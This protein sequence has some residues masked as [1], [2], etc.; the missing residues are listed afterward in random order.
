MDYKK[1]NLTLGEF[2]FFING[3]ETVVI[4]SA[5]DKTLWHG[6]AKILYTRS[7]NTMLENLKTKY[8]DNV[9][10]NDY[11]EIVIQLQ[12]EVTKED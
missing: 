9:N 11:C 2:I 3:D 7:S 12:P 6:N 4:L 8:V 10:C 5:D 1:K